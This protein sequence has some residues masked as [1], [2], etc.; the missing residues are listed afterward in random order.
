MNI[1]LTGG[2]GY[3]GSHTCVMLQKLGFT[4]VIY[5]NFSNS[6]LSTIQ[7]ITEISGV[8]PEFVEG[9]ILDF[10]LLKSTM[11]RH[12]ISAVIHFAGLK[13][14]QESV[15]NPF[16]YNE[17]NLEGSKNLLDAM[18]A[19]NVFSIIFSSSATVY[20]DPKY[21]PITEDH[22]LDPKNPYGVSKLEVEKYL[23]DLAEKNSKWKIVSLRYFNPIGA[24]ESGLLYENS[25]SQQSNIMPV[26]LNIA[27]G[28]N[29]SLN[30]YG[31]NY[32][33]K[34]GTG[35]RDYI[36]IMDLADAH[37][38]ALEFLA[39]NEAISSG[40]LPVNI[41]TGKG[42][43]VLELVNKFQ[44]STEIKIPYEFKDKRSGDI[45]IS[46]ADASLAWSK[47]SWRAKRSLGEMCASAWKAAL[48]RKS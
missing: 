4:T 9:D 2:A 6:S 35:I 37:C 40:F 36:H 31:K 39:N 19:C 47:F 41:G 5:D 1:L 14:V 15:E 32:D 30:I 13:S 12:K 43:S 46:F 22:P 38:A 34:D 26:L 42:Y 8:V 21:L 25:N 28:K 44:K 27:L 11:V 48:L 3:I 23:E 20:G 29:K 33:T 24:H 7:N 18:Q 16:L 10:S 17:V 45:D